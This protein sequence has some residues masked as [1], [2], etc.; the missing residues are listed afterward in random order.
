M[1]TEPTQTDIKLGAQIAGC[2]LQINQRAANL[3]LENFSALTPGANFNVK[4]ALLNSDVPDFEITDWVAENFNLPHLELHGHCLIQGGF[5]LSRWYDLD[6]FYVEDRIKSA[7]QATVERYKGIIAEWD[8]LGEVVSPIGGLTNSFL[9]HKL[10]IDFPVKIFRWIREVDPDV[11]LYYSD[12]GMES[13]DKLDA[14]LRLCHY[15]LAEGCDLAGI[16][17]QFHHHSRGAI[18]RMGIKR[19]IRS[20]QVLG[21][22]TKLS[23][24]TIWQDLTKLGSLAE[25]IQAHC[26]ASLLELAI[27]LKCQSYTFWA[28]FNSYSWRHP[29]ESPGLWDF[30]FY[31]TLNFKEVEKICKKYA[32]KRG[33]P[34][35]LVVSEDS[36]K[37]NLPESIATK[38]CCD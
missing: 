34:K 9:R 31:P 26:Y 23:E 20:T 22:K 25:Q 2:H 10:G 18:N 29:E 12:Y 5:A 6:G 17:L 11:P 13:P 32:I 38:N 1:T 33:R 35:D 24:V 28:P 21:L 3:V 14:V 27:E 19:A 4:R 7:I 36:E 16:S 8:F 15:L 37:E 30:D